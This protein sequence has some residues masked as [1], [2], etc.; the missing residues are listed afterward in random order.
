MFYNL[1]FINSIHLS[2]AHDAA[3]KIGLTSAIND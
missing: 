1:E 2:A 3:L